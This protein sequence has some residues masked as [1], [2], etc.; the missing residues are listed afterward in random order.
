VFLRQHRHE[1]FEPFQLARAYAARREV[2]PPVPSA[3]LAVSTIVRARTGVS[4]DEI[5]RG[6]SGG[7]ALAFTRG[8]GWGW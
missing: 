5:D 2:Q 6:D 4:D 7:P 3:Q 8:I 1:V